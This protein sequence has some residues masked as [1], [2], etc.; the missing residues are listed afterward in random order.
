M[1]R[2]PL[3]VGLRIFKSFQSGMRNYVGESLKTG[4]AILDY[5]CGGGGFVYAAL[6]QGYN[7]FGVEIDDKYLKQAAKFPTPPSNF[8]EHLVIY[9]GNILP[10]PSHTFDCVFSWY[11]LEHVPDLWQTLMEMIRVLKPG[12]IL[13]L[14]SEDARNAVESHLQIPWPPFL[15]KKF[16]PAY[17]DEWG[18][19]DPPEYYMM[20]IFYITMP[21]IVSFLEFF[22]I[23]ILYKTEINHDTFKKESLYIHS[24]DDARN[25]ARELKRMQRD[26]TWKEPESYVHIWGRKK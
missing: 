24:E 13:S 5:G 12:G 8:N 23:S 17:L 22:D 15:R 4:A 11:V 16:I 3:E 21:Q 10:F 2:D 9:D 1:K 26:G 18:I 6:N 25:A 14:H 19:K 20:N 7:S